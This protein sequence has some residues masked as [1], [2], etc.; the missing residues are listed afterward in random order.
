MCIEK[1]TPLRIS[2]ILPLLVTVLLAGCH[3]GS[4]NKPQQFNIAIR[5]MAGVSLDRVTVTILDQRFPF[6]KLKHE[7]RASVAFTSI[8]LPEND[9]VIKTAT[10]SA[11]QGKTALK[12]EAKVDDL[13][14]SEWNTYLAF[15]L[16]YSEDNE[17]TARRLER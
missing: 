11:T 7:Q 15:E 14:F 10:I 1:V 13:N 8:L 4:K 5:N 9:P 16:F 6:D 12:L 17:F 3:S 2:C